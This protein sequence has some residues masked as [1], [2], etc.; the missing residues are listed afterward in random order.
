VSSLLEV[1]TG[2]PRRALQPGDTLI[3]EGTV[4]SAMYV[5]VDGTM[6]VEKDGVAITEI[7][8]AGAC[9]GEIS[10]LLDVPATANVVAATPAVVAVIEDA[11][12]MLGDDS[13]IGIALARV[14]AGRVQRMTTYLADL[15][16]QYA[17]HDG[18]LGM[19]DVVLQE[20]AHT[21]A[22]GT[23]LRSERDPYPE[24]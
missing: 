10:L 4:H 20:L 21:S 2:L 9:I 12:T 8:D 19:I 18:G 24:Y 5:L 17:E 13:R 16:R 14:L 11:R 1:V 3:V 7:R 22:S 23:E 6:R 15:K